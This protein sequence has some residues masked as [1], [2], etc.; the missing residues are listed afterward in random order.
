VLRHCYY[1]SLSAY[2]LLGKIKIEKEEEESEE[3]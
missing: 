3:H 1:D 2:E